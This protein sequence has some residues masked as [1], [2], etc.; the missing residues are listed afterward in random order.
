MRSGLTQEQSRLQPIFR[1]KKGKPLTLPVL[2]NWFKSSVERIV[3]VPDAAQYS[4]HS[5]RSYLA[6]ALLAAGA[7]TAEIQALLRWKTV[8]ALEIYARMNP[9]K[10]HNLLRRAA[11]ADVSSVVAAQLPCI[12]ADGHAQLL[13]DALPAFM[14]QA[15][16][17]DVT[18]PHDE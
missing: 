2:R 8:E 5:F 9:S 17:D 11:D 6:S 14:Q 15:S 7:T 3:G 4:L 12:D 18:M 1:D 13:H 16:L 10:Y